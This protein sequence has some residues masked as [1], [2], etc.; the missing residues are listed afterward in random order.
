MK[1]NLNEVLTFI[2]NIPNWKYYMEGGC[3]EFYLKLKEKFPDAEAYYNSNHVITKIDDK[4]YD[5]SGRVEK[6]N[7]ISVDIYYTHE[8]MNEIF[9]I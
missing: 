4:Y 5:S 8:F 6:D 2:Y 7:H 3:Y 9:N 1:Q